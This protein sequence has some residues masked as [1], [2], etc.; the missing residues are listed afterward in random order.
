M[1]KIYIL[2]NLFTAGSLFCGLMAI[3]QA[4]DQGDWLLAV[5][6]VFL[7]AILDSFDGLVARL[8]RTQ[9]A[10]GANFDSLADAISFGVAP[11]CIVY[12]AVAPEYPWIAKV[13][14][15]FYAV[16]AAMRLARFNVQQSKEEKKSFVGLPSPGGAMTALSVFWVFVNHPQI[17]WFV[18]P[19][20]ALPV[21]MVGLGCLMFSNFP[22]FGPKSVNL[23]KRHQDEVFVVLVIILFI[24]VL[25]KQH[26]DLIA[27][28]IFVPYALSGPALYLME[29]WRPQGQTAKAKR[30]RAADADAPSPDSSPRK[31]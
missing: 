19:D 26:I 27:A 16:F 7:A 3:F 9:S 6:L 18:S 14:C 22:Y 31:P 8:T 17:E 30:G 21:V 25:L 13:T 1:R 11:A 29:Q 20:K 5:H 10:F 4:F 15:G 12:T 2:P 23:A 24:I 28:G